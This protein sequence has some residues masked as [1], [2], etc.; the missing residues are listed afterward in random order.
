MS[1]WDNS[2]ALRQLYERRVRQ[3]EPEMTCAAQAAKLLAPLVTAG[4]TVLDV[5]CGSGYF[6]HSL[7]TR[8]LPVTYWGIDASVE[9]IK[10]GQASLAAYGLPADHLQVG[11][12]EELNE[13]ADH[14]ICMNVLTYLANFHQPLERLLEAA[15]QSVIIRESLAEDASYNYVADRYLDPGVTLKTYIN[16]YPI[17]EVRKFIIEHGFTTEVVTDRYTGGQPQMVI[18]YPHYWT[19]IVARRNL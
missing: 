5:G 10:I 18:D 15:R 8:A 11:R 3:Q 9:L 1:T 6:Y 2:T 17:A 13:T 14:I 12:L 7:V 4:D 19:F 16:T